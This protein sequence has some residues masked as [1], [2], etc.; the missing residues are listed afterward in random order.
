MSINQVSGQNQNISRA[1]VQN[2]D[3]TQTAGATGKAHKGHHHQAAQAPTADTVSLSDS[4]KALAAAREAVK[5]TPDVR[6]QKVADIKQ[7]VT[8]GTYQVSSQVLAKKMLSGTNNL[9]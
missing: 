7:S 3:A 9:S 8:D 4:A 6:E 5:N 2:A 1:Y